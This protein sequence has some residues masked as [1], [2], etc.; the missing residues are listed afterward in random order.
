MG[1]GLGT[2]WAPRTTPRVRRFLRRD[3]AP[4]CLLPRMVRVQE[5]VAPSGDVV[6]RKPL[7]GDYCWDGEVWLRWSGRRWAR[8][9]YSLHPEQLLSSRRIDEHPSI[10][11]ERGRRALARAVQDQVASNGASVV[12][13]GPSGVILG[14]QRHVSHVFHAVLTVLTLG[15]WGVVWLALARRRHQDLVRF[16]IDPWGNVWSTPVTG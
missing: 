6:R 15:A 13:D 3:D 8:A 16:D 9:A 4:W 1:R 5:V 12:H 14:Y 7:H 11:V 10:D 2:L